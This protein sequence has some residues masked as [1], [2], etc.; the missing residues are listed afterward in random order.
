MQILVISSPYEIPEDWDLGEGPAPTDEQLAAIARAHAEMFAA[1]RAS[2]ADCGSQAHSA[3]D[4]AC[5]R[6]FSF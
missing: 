2:C 4:N 6:K 1:F 3:G 5:E